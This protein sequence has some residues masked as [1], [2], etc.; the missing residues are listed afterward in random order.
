ML[1]LDAYAKT[2]MMC[3]FSL[4]FFVAV[5][6]GAWW[7]GRRTWKIAL[8]PRPVFW[9]CLCLWFVTMSVL[10]TLIDKPHFNATPE[11]LDWMFMF[12]A[13]LGIPFATPLLA[14]MVW[15]AGHQWQD[16]RVDIA[17][18]AL[19]LL[20]TFALGCAVSNMHDVLWCGVITK[21]YTQ[22][23]P[24]GYDLDIFVAFGQRFGIAAETLADYVTL[25]PYAAV[26]ILGELIVATVS[27]RQLM[28]Q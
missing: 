20:G 19:L 3:L 12:S 21:G 14:G 24:A 25:G 17:P 13:F 23:Y 11:T 4:G 2:W 18:F 6:A 7:F 22:H 26:L 10:L 9:T 16:K 28:A 5:A 15:A 27:F 8:P 1:I